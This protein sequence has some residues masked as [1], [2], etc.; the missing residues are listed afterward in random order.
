M[1]DDTD[2]PA[3]HSMDACWF[4]VDRDGRV[5]CFTTGEAGALP[6]GAEVS[7]ELGAAVDALP[8]RGEPLVEP[9]VRPPDATGRAHPG[10]D[11]PAFVR[12]DYPMPVTV[13]LDATEP[14][15][16]EIASGDARA[17]RA[18]A[19]WAV[20]FARLTRELVQRLH[21]ADLCR[22]CVVDYGNLGDDADAGSPA[23]RGMYKYQH[24][25]ENWIAGPYGRA[26]A[27]SA[28]IS[29]DDLPREARGALVRFP[30]VSF[31]ADP[32]VQPVEHVACASWE[33]AWL[34]SDGRHVRAFSAESEDDVAEQCGRD[35]ALVFVRGGGGGG[36]KPGG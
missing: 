1:T 32:Y 33:R 23:A 17:V 7:A 28:P 13:F 9:Y 19:G 31:A 22:G 12:D 36:E 8:P 11:G 14:V 29:V 5:A 20:R 35:E 10:H 27:P 16:R 21:D 4:A 25:C 6:L 26:A 2:F 15:A 18:A 30:T 34:A 24:T 3:A